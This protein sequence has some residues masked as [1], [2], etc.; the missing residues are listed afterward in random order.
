[1]SKGCGHSGKEAR[2][3]VEKACPYGNNLVSLELS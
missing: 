2:A 3:K 1:M